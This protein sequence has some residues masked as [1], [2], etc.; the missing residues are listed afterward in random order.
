VA[1]TGKANYSGDG[2][3]ATLASFYGPYD[4]ALD[5]S[6]NL[7][8]ADCYNNR[9][10]K[11]TMSTGII[12]TVAGT[13]KSGYSGDGGLATLSK[14]SYP[15]GVAVDASGNVYISDTSNYR[16]RLLTVRT[17]IITTVAGDGTLGYGG[18][19]GLATS[20]RLS[21]TEGIAVDALGNIYVADQF[22]NR[23]RM[24]TKE[25]G[26]IT[27]VAGNGGNGAFTFNGD[28]GEATSALVDNPYDVAVDVSGNLYISE[29]ERNRIRM[30]TKSTGLI[31][32]VAGDG[33]A[34]Y[35]G[36]GGLATS[37]GLS[38]PYGVAVDISGNLFITQGTKDDHR[39]R[40]VTKSTGII[41]TVAGTGPYG[42]SGDGGQATSAKLNAPQ[43]VAVDASG[44]VYIADMA[45]GR[46]RVFA[47]NSPPTLSPS[48]VPTLAPTL[49]PSGLPTVFSSLSPSAAPT[50]IPTLSP[51]AAPTISSTL[52][53]SAAPTISSTLSP[54]AAPTISPSTA[55]T[56]APSPDAVPATA[57]IASSPTASSTALSSGLLPGVAGGVGGF[58]LIL[59]LLAVICFCKRR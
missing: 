36:N 42:Y 30:V 27:T 49:S 58:L 55:L 9:I 48:P 26:V 10:R 51:S 24:I 43:N 23:I 28:G 38:N 25:T 50:R 46:I 21:N 53:P 44:N 4:V 11:I 19:G 57:L 47:T 17:G 1:G 13:G 16:I 37:A 12:T 39:I 3:Q 40:M 32:T 20:S 5:T 7:Y 6:G 45:N 34:E 22:N 14:I 56:A 35:T 54:S 31:S 59:L 18:D 29:T 41:T 33:T 52:S 15:Q 8:V 2:A